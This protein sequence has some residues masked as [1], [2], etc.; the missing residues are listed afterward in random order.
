MS[1][2]AAE[3]SVELIDENIITE[4]MAAELFEKVCHGLDKLHN[5]NVDKDKVAYVHCDIKPR[6]FLKFLLYNLLSKLYYLIFA[7]YQAFRT[8]YQNVS[9]FFRFCI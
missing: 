9:P 2:V 6:I 4:K 7:R 1:A 3:E 8:S 5:P